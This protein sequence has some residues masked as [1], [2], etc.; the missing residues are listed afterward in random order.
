MQRRLGVEEVGVQAV[1]VVARPLCLAEP[2]PG[3]HRR[4]AG[5]DELLQLGLGLAQRARGGVGALRP[6][7]VGL[8]ALQRGHGDGRPIG[9]R[10]TQFVGGDV[11]LGRLGIV[12]ARGH[13]VPVV[14]QRGGDLLL[15]GHRHERVL[16][17]QRQQLTEAVDREQVGDVRPIA[18]VLERGDLGQLPVLGGQLCRRRHLDLLDLLERALREGGEKGQA[19]DLDVEELA[20]HRP[21]LGRRVEVEDVAP[22]RELASILHL[23]DALVATSH[24]L[25]GRLV[26]VD[27]VALGDREAVRA[28]SRIGHLLG[29]RARGSHHH[30]RGLG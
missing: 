10:R 9:Q 17:E 15:V 6:E 27:Q 23:L 11:E 8:V 1:Q 20:A 5:A 25:V 4:I 28:Q 3:D 24:Q 7:D 21:L 2:C 12:E 13:V 30:R 18:L 26:Q 19:F 22:D 29:E 14:G 16:G